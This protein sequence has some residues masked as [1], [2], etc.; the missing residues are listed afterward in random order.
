MGAEDN[1]PE[2]LPHV[3]LNAAGVGLTIGDWQ[4]GLV[5]ATSTDDRYDREQE[6]DRI[7]HQE[8][9][10]REARR[11]G[12]KAPV[13]APSEAAAPVKLVQLDQPFNQRKVSI[14]QRTGEQ[15]LDIVDDFGRSTIV[16]HGLTLWARGRESY[17]ILPD[18]PLSARQECHWSEER[19]RGDWKVRT[20]TY[21][22]MTASKTHW[23]V[24]G[25]L[26][27]YEGDEKIL[28][29]SWDKKI[30]RKLV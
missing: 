28:T 30:R 29:R 21:S 27:A 17:S 13:F 16:E 4:V 3:G 7:K 11:R 9:D 18:D 1:K 15:R 2:N 14:D 8:D 12:E 5:P 24:T 10:E 22:A 25:R 23:H 19:S 26:E 6:R 20:E